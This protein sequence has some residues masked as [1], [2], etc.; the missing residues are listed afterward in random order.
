MTER[1]ATA[2]YEDYKKQ[3]PVLDEPTFDKTDSVKQLDQIGQLS[4]YEAPLTNQKMKQLTK[5]L[6]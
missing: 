6:E 4:M 2:Y 3:E 1:S 5:Q